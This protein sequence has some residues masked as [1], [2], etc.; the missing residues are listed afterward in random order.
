[1]TKCQQDVIETLRADMV[2]SYQDSIDSGY[3]GDRVW[4]LGRIEYWKT[5]PA[6]TLVRI[7]NAARTELEYYGYEVPG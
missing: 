3:P 7:N 1:M 6:L 5:T 2:A 4:E